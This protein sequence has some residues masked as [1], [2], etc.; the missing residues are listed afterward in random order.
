MGVFLSHIDLQPLFY[1]FIIVIGLMVV[2]V[3]IFTFKLM[4]VV[5]DITV[6]CLVFWMHGGTLTGGMAA[7]VAALLAGLFIPPIIRYLLNR[8]E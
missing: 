1:G 6:F 3:H 5:V 2:A 7:A 8:K 4:A